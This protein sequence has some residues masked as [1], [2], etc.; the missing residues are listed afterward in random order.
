MP[1]G[2]YNHNKIKGVQFSEE[3]KLNISNALKK[4]KKTKEHRENH[5][6]S[7]INGGKV[8]GKNNPRYIDGRKQKY[9]EWR[10][11]IF[12]RDNWTCQECK[13]YACYLNVHHIK[14]Q[15]NFPELRYELSNGVTLCY[16]CH[17]KKHPKGFR[18]GTEEEYKIKFDYTEIPK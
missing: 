8:K 11:T 1:K 3:R 10:K 18:R 13:K 7:L 9:N 6:K 5:S 2:K 16:N 14:S 12:E 17:T 15:K 4:Y